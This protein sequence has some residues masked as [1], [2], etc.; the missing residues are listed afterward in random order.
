MTRL[1]VVVALVAAGLLLLALVVF[2]WGEAGSGSAESRYRGSVPPEGIELPQ[3]ALRDYRGGLVTTDSLRGKALA[4]TFLDTQCEEACPVIAGQVAQAFADLSPETRARAAAYAV[5]V[6]PAEDTPERVRA[7]L[8]R[9]RAER[10]L[11]YLIGPEAALRRA[12]RDFLVL[13]S[14]QSGDDDI[15]SAPVRIYDPGGRWVATLHAGADLTADN[16]AH[17]LR[18][19]LS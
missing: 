7:F 15:H 5:S 11:G 17:D 9:H 6:D 4:V 10:A 13:P 14:I 19:A 16:L 8:R 12:W 3:F 2:G 18:E 1:L